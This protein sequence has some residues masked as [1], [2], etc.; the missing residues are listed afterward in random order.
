MAFS[1]RP[2]KLTEELM[3]Q[4]ISLV[5]LGNWKYVVARAVGVGNR[6]LTEWIRIGK[7]STDHDC[8]YKRLWLGI[9]KAEAEAEIDMVRLVVGAARTDPDY[10]T[11]YLTHKAPERWASDRGEL[12]KAIK[13]YNA[14]KDEY[15]RATSET[16]K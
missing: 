2:F 10:A 12:T 15:Q 1:G 7:A 4:I 9:L 13:E 11:W 5:R 16:E 6:T 14:A 8:M 3:D